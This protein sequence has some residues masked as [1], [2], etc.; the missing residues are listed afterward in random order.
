MTKTTSFEDLKKL[1]SE[2]YHLFIN[3]F[4]KLLAQQLP[5]HSCNYKIM[6]R[7]GREVLFE[8]I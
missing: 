1:V 2:D 5:S 8:S 3:L 4:G 6:I 7:E